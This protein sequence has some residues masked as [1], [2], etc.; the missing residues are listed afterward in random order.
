MQKR[1]EDE[2]QGVLENSTA[3]RA[4]TLKELMGLFGEVGEDEEGR[5]FV[6]GLSLIHI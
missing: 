5:A 2:I 3:K 4:L 1:K 6:V